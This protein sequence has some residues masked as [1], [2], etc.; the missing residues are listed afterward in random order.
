[1]LKRIK[2][3]L[4]AGIGYDLD[5]YINVNTGNNT[6]LSDFT[7][8]Q[9]GTATGKSPFSS[10]LTLNLLYDTRKN[11]FNFI[12]GSYTNIVYRHNAEFIGSGNN[13]QS[14]YIDLRKY[15]S[16]NNGATQ[17][18]LL[19][20][21]AY[22]WTTLTAGTPYLALPA[23]GM[24]PYN[25]SGRGIDQNRYR[26]EGLFYFETEYRKSISDNG[27]FGFVVFANINSASQPNSHRFEYLNPAGG[28]G[29]RIKFNKKSD[30]SICIDYGISKG[31]SDL[32]LSL[33]EAF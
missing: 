18:N 31:Y 32:I 25:R 6:P 2:P 15:I 9:Y 13:A 11:L 28:A 1:V 30:Q 17:K 22:Y 10:G 14:L 4:Y 26:G 7:G 5:Y 29:L 3:Y 12:P 8:Y 20:F 24:D 16:L 21:W 23:I 19:A 27:L 33:D